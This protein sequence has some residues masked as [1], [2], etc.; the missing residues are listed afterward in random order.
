VEANAPRK[1]ENLE[2]IFGD[3]ESCGGF[4][5]ESEEGKTEKA[6]LKNCSV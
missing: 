5:S 2:E 4:S 3:V 6:D 1:N